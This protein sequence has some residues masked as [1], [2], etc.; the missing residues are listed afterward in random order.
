M[1]LSCGKVA[2]SCGEVA[3]RRLR[4]SIELWKSS[5]GEVALRRLRSSI[6]LWKVA[7]SCGEVALSCGE[8]HS[9]VTLSASQPFK[10]ERKQGQSILK[11]WNFLKWMFYC[12]DD[13]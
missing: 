11:V 9:I 1:A 2:L 13:K 6:E 10:R 12:S 5:C 4:S 7:L 8:V 3:L